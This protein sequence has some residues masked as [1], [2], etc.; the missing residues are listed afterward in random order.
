VNHLSGLL[1]RELPSVLAI[2]NVLLIQM[3]IELMDHRCCLWGMDHDQ[4]VEALELFL[5]RGYLDQFLAGVT[6]E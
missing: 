3:D 6:G 5:T 2:D 4:T 1:F